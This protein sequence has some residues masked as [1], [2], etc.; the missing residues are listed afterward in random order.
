MCDRMRSPETRLE[1]HLSFVSCATSL[2]TRYRH[3]TNYVYNGQRDTRTTA[4]IYIARSHR[5]EVGTHPP[6]RRFRPAQ[7]P[8]SGLG[9]YPRR[10]LTALARA[11]VAE[12]ADARYR[13]A[14]RSLESST[15]LA[16][17][18]AAPGATCRAT[19]ICVYSQTHAPPV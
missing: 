4:P 3:P 13:Y 12:V 1:R 2:E 7:L 14:R 18:A 16:A 15:Q 11:E 10:L 19:V 8:S 5:T 9:R 6:Q 17:P